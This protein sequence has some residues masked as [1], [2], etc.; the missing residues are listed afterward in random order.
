MET[1]KIV[2][3]GQMRKKLQRAARRCK[4]ADTPKSGPLSRPAK[5]D[6]YREA[7]TVR[8]NRPLRSTARA[9]GRVRDPGRVTLQERE[10]KRLES[11]RSD[12]GEPRITLNQVGTTLKPAAAL[13]AQRFHRRDCRR[14]AL[15]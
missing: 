6:C 12:Q 10:S 3:H 11:H 15:P 14:S 13:H 9:W 1:R 2:L 4:D 8:A 5:N 7:G